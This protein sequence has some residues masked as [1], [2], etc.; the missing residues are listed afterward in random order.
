MGKLRLVAGK[1]GE[2][3][4]VLTRNA[5]R[6]KNKVTFDSLRI[7]FFQSTLLFLLGH[8]VQQQCLTLPVS[9][10]SDPSSRESVLI[11]TYL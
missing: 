2:T 8:A 11:T 3:G 10:M 4:G 9:N 1:S 6:F 7:L 5:E